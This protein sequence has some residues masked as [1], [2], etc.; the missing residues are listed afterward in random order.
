M[1]KTEISCSKIILATGHSARDI[2]ELLKNKGVFLEKKSFALGVRVEHS[3][4][5]IDQ[6]QYKCNSRGKYLPPTP[7]QF[8]S[9][10]ME[11]EFIHSACALEALLHHVQLLK[12]K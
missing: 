12:M 5:L 7:I 10:L 4:D 9:K 6:I 8:L 2:F 11:E 3:Q 1:D